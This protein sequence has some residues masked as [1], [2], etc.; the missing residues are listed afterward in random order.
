MLYAVHSARPISTIEEAIAALCE[1]ESSCKENQQRLRSLSQEVIHQR[2]EQGRIV[3]QFLALKQYGDDLIGQLAVKVD[4]SEQTLRDAHA[5]YRRAGSRV[6]FLKQWATWESDDITVTWTMV[7]NWGRKA[8]PDSPKKAALQFEKERALL[9]KATARLESRSK[10]LLDQAASSYPE[11]ERDEVIGVVERAQE[12]VMEVRRDLAGI[13][14]EK[15]TRQQDESYLNYIRAMNCIACMNPETIAHHLDRGGLSTK[16]S[17]YLTVSLCQKCH[18]TLHDTA[19]WAFWE[20][21]AVN[22]WKQA[23]ENLIALIS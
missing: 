13:A 1:I 10:D 14:L 8:L 5:V 3:D 4:L 16:G 11:G 23:C 17:D 15:P 21:V 9:E 2:F 18:Q 20:E 6:E 7:R 12:A 19:E 22:P